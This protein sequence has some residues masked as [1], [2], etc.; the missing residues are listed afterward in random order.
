MIE[1]LKRQFYIFLRRMRLYIDSPSF[2]PP[3]EERGASIALSTTILNASCHL[4]PDGNK[5]IR[6]FI[7]PFS[8]CSLSNVSN[9]SRVIFCCFSRNQTLIYWWGPILDRGV[10]NEPI[11]ILSGSRGNCVLSVIRNP[12]A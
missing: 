9:S 6:F 3:Q 5:S 12:R 10:S 4:A 8:C 2:K 11:V 1:L 7:H